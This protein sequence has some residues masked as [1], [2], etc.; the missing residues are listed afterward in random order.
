MRRR[1]EVPRHPRYAILRKLGTGGS[2]SVYLAED[3][4]DDGRRVALKVG[5]ARLGSGEL[6]EEFRILR[7][8]RH[9]GIARSFDFGRIPSTS[10]PYFT[11]EH[12]SGPDLEEES[13]RLRRGG[14]PE[15][16][17]RLGRIFL[18]VVDALAYL[19]GKKLLHLDLKPSN[20]VF[21]GDR[22]KLIDFGL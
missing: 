1:A 15:D 5:R 21:A 19:H 12:I 7:E 8:L 2:S 9:P 18:D 6:R 14:S 3:R 22:P 13:A 10:L 4:L 17:S 20:V 11:L 16:I